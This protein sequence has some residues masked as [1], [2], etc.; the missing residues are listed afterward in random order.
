MD[1]SAALFSNIE[2]KKNVAEAHVMSGDNLVQINGYDE[3]KSIGAA[4]G[5]YSSVNDMTKWMLMHLND[6]LYNGEDR[7]VSSK[8]HR[9]MWSAK[10]NM[11]FDATPKG[12]Y[13]THYEAYGLGWF[14]QD[15]NG[16]TTVSHTGGLA[17]MLSQV[18]LIPE[19]NAG[20]VV[21]TNSMPGG[22]SFVSIT[23]EIQDELL[24]VDGRNWIEAMQMGIES[25]GSEADS[26]V[27]AVWETVSDAN[28]KEIH[29]ED[30]IGTYKDDWFGDVT[31][32]MRKD[33][34]WFVSKRSPKLTGKMSFYKANTFAIKWE[35]K[36]MECDA[37]ASFSL[38][39]NGKAQSIK[40]KGISPAIDFSFDFQDLDLQRIK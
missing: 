12:V 25:N 21:L 1:N 4:G 22:Y 16:Y 18:V 38:D 5:I 11:F 39:E 30:Y 19:L 7:L 26:V 31:I 37:F 15:K 9:E 8:S 14:L 36:D 33:E 27:N 40:M 13:K 10:T 24:G 17:G 6:G 2:K 28:S 32:E 29:S 35:F 23:N 20:V 3:V 34:L